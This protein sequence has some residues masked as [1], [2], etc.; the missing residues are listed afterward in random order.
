MTEVFEQSVKTKV[1]AEGILT[2]R[3]IMNLPGSIIDLPTIN[4]RDEADIVEFGLK[5]NVDVVAASFVR[6]ANCIE[7]IRVALGARGA[8]VKVFAK[9]QNEQ[10]L[11]HYDEILA[12]A[13][14]III[15]RAD[16]SMDVAPEKVVIA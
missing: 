9:I 2:E 4:E 3:M 8:H 10:G 5:Y 15:A 14:G 6:S 1:V 12:A 13:D 7:T 11:Q 16:L